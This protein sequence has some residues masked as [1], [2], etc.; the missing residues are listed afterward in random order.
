MTSTAEIP[1]HTIA[2][3]SSAAVVQPTHTHGNVATTTTTPTSDGSVAPTDEDKDKY[4]NDADDG[5]DLQSP[6]ILVG[7]RRCGCNLPTGARTAAAND[8][9]GAG[10]CN[11]ISSSTNN[12]DT[13]NTNDTHSTRH[14]RGYTA[15]TRRRRRAHEP[16]PGVHAAADGEAAT[17]TS[18]TNNDDTN[19]T[20]D[21]DSTRH[22]RGYMADTRRRRHAHE[23]HPG[24]HAA[25]DGEA[26]TD[27]HD[28]DMKSTVA[29]RA[30]ARVCATNRS[31]LVA[32]QH[33]NSMVPPRGTTH[34]R[35]HDAATN[36][37]A[38]TR[39]PPISDNAHLR[40]CT[41]TIR[42][43]TD[44]ARHPLQL[45]SLLDRATAW[46]PSDAQ[47]LPQLIATLGREPPG[48]TG[49]TYDPAWR[50]R[51]NTPLPPWRRTLSMHA[52]IQHAA[53]CPTLGYLQRAATHG[54]DI[55]YRADVGETGAVGVPNGSTATT[56]GAWLSRQ[57]RR[58]L[59]SGIM[60]LG[61]ARS[62]APLKLSPVHVVPKDST[63]RDEK[64]HRLIT[65][66]SAGGPRSLN[67]GILKPPFQEATQVYMK[68][69]DFREDV[70]S[71]LRRGITPWMQKRD[72]DN[73][74][75]RLASRVDDWPRVAVRVR[76]DRAR[77]LFKWARRC[78]SDPSEDTSSTPDVDPDRVRPGWEND[79][80][81]G[82]PDNFDDA[83]YVTLYYS[84]ATF[85][86]R[87]SG[88]LFMCVSDTIVYACRAAGDLWRNFLDD[89]SG[90][91][92]TWSDA[93]RAGARLT[94]LA[95]TSGLPVS[96][97][98]L[99]KEGWPSLV[100]EV[101]GVTF[102]SMDGT[103]YLSAARRDKL[104]ALLRT[105]VHRRRIPMHT[106][107]QVAGKLIWFASVHEAARPY[108]S[109]WF[110]ATAAAHRRATAAGV[111]LT[112]VNIVV[113][114]G[115]QRD[116]K[117]FM[118]ACSRTVPVPIL[119]APTTI[120][121]YTDA[122]L[123]AW[124]ACWDGHWSNGSWEQRELDLAGNNIFILEF[125]A[126]NI[127]IAAFAESFRGQRLH[128]FVDNEAVEHCIRNRRARHP[129]AR[130]MLRELQALLLR[131]GATLRVT[132]VRSK[133]NTADAVSRLN[134]PDAFVYPHA[135]H[136]SWPV[137]AHPQPASSALRWD[138][139]GTR[140]RSSAEHAQ[141]VTGDR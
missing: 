13:N 127:T 41:S 63:R 116:C 23:P 25:A 6:V 94:Y 78:R 105:V 108:I 50:P 123:F 26:A 18:S 33:T 121:L 107:Q 22:S 2:V 37:G 91:H 3:P 36:M 85:G 16:H 135:P 71:F 129:L 99:D 8:E 83:A 96:L 137:D 139:M 38:G 93:M 32:R 131:L 19:N 104:A 92:A 60:M 61:D 82:L 73:A 28:D 130:A 84:T 47:P 86:V 79:L 77:E 101:L 109:S 54:F 5:Y 90:V 59:Q 112:R 1:T 100:V 75:N 98:K 133:A 10:N 80:P 138:C 49:A 136:I 4:E 140:W 27:T 20:N 132:G 7:S 110:A 11:G 52:L 43:D 124:G 115:M 51:G 81:E 122:S 17:D 70:A 29:Y 9:T 119:L 34:L 72:H 95:N 113:S 65:D 103:M 44:S 126:V 14:S 35:Q 128:V 134:V 68:V 114:R 120:D 125:A 40:T 64:K 46:T 57:V 97:D 76:I 24:V 106:A 58:R 53:G 74:Y 87:S 30:L 67:A 69:A 42:H 102:N 12:N 141:L 66:A 31:V 15:D 45:P 111:P 56:H 39:V 118:Y 21:T 55:G 48:W 62:P 88:Y 117:W 89:Y